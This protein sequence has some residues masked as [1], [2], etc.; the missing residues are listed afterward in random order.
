MDEREEKEM[1]LPIPRQEDLQVSEK[2][3]RGDEWRE[4]MEELEEWLGLVSLGCERI[5]SGGDQVDPFI[6]TYSLPISSS[7]YPWTTGDVRVYRMHGMID[8]YLLDR[9]LALAE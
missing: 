9:T 2:E 1:K 6:S 3:Q 5:R 8:A 7:P 4:G